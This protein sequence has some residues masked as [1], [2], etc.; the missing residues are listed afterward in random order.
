M[1]C[2]AAMLIFAIL[3]GVLYSCCKIRN[4]AVGGKA[5]PESPPYTTE[6]YKNCTLETNSIYFDATVIPIG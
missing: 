3:S 2:C 4:P 1:N 5:G 6:L